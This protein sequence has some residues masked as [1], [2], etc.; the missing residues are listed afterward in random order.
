MVFHWGNVNISWFAGHVPRWPSVAHTQIGLISHTGK[1]QSELNGQENV[2]RSFCLKISANCLSK[3]IDG[4]MNDERGKSREPK[5][6]NS[7]CKVMSESTTTP[8]PPSDPLQP[9][10]AF[11]R[12]RRKVML[13]TG[14]GVT[15]EERLADLRMHQTRHCEKTKEYLMNYSQSQICAVFRLDFSHFHRPCCC[16]YAE[17]SQGKWVPST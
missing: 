10:R 16:I 7:R 4:I 15:E 13:V 9:L 2:L 6:E 1:E 17:T 12:W 8:S 3:R 11:E 14:I 5:L